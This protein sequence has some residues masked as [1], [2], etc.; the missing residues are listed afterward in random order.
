VDP[1]TVPPKVLL[2]APAASFVTGIALLAFSAPTGIRAL[3]AGGVILLILS[4]FLFVGTPIVAMFKSQMV[5][6]RAR[7]ARTADGGR[8][9]GATADGQ[10]LGRMRW[11]LWP[12][13]PK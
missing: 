3:L 10:K 4:A 8:T 11:R 6:E 1:A 2:A 12:R 9:V 7:R 5:E 13:S